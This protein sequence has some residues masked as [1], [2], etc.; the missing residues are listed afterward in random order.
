M[1]LLIQTVQKLLDR[2]LAVLEKEISLYTSD[3]GLWKVAGDIKNPA[4]NLCLHLCGNL[5]YYIGAVLGNSGYIRNR[6]AEFSTKGLTKEELLSEI[7]KT[8]KA[9]SLALQNLNPALLETTYPVEVFKDPMTTGYFLIHLSA[10]LGYHLG[11]INYHRRLLQ[12][13]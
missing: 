8:R 3:S 5:Q 6:D 7:A 11:Q 13:L 10:H 1:S 9:V 4:G 2:D 12:M